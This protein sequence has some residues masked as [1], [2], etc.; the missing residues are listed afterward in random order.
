MGDEWTREPVREFA[1]TSRS[2]RSKVSGTRHGCVGTTSTSWLSADALEYS[3]K[4]VVT[5]PQGHAVRGT[6]E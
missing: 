1:G 3:Q 2:L 4:T 6:M 5:R